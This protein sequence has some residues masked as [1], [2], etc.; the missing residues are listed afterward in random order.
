MSPLLTGISVLGSLLL[1]V[2]LAPIIMQQRR[3]TREDERWPRH[4]RMCALATITTIDIRQDWKEGERWEQSPWNG[5][6]VRQRSWQTYYDITAEWIQEQSKQRTILR[7][8]VW[9]DEVTKAPGIGQTIVVV[10]D[11]RHPEH[12]VVDM[13]SFSIREDDRDDNT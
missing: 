8:R 9:P 3:N 5:R 12:A 11:L 4:K 2:S 1:L 7:S 6:L 10:V 13:K